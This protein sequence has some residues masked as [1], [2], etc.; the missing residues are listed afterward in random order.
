M[1]IN[2]ILADY[3]QAGYVNSKATKVEEGK[4]LRRS[5]NDIGCLVSN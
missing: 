5:L 2:G 3:Y 4:S 1:G